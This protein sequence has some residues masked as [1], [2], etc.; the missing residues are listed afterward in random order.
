MYKL[1]QHLMIISHL[2]LGYLSVSNDGKHL[3]IYLFF[4]GLFTY[5]LYKTNKYEK[6]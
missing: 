3:Y 5:R 2:S 1:F 6:R 4:S